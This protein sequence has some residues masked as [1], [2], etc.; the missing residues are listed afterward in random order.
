LN[1][2]IMELEPGRRACLGHS[3][4]EAVGRPITLIIPP[5]RLDEE[6]KDSWRGFG[7]A[8]RSSISRRSGSAK[9]A[10]GSM[11]PLSIS[12]V[13]DAQG[14]IVGASKIA[15]DITA[16]RRAEEALRTSDAR[17]R[18]LTEAVPADRLGT[19][20]PPANSST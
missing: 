20:T 5:E 12:P 14:R 2:V 3:A 17:F 10:R 13:R 15:R 9:T 18:T 19:P 8:N 11:S 1:G 6:P 16:R 4:A 7:A